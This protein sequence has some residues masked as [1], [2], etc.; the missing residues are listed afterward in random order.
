[1]RGAIAAELIGYQPRRLAPL[2]LQQLAEK[3][4]S[5]SA[6]TTSLDEDIDHVSILIDGSP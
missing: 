5:S 2:A 3:P 1:M 6:I 4:L